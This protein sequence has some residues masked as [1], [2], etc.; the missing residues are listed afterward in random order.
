MITKSSVWQLGW[1]QCGMK[2]NVMGDEMAR[3]S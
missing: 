3:E 1:W 2:P